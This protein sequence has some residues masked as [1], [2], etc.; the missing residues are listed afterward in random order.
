MPRIIL[1]PCNIN[2]SDIFVQKKKNAAPNKENIKSNK[3]ISKK[4]KKQ[5]VGQLSK[6]T[7]LNW[8]WL[9]YHTYFQLV[10]LHK[11]LKACASKYCQKIIEFLHARQVGS[12]AK[13]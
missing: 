2:L 5:K 6:Q 9:Q 11:P 3:I 13:L 12:F 4:A 8:M 1:I 7:F 10:Q